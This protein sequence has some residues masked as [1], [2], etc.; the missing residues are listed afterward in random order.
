MLRADLINS[1]Q[2]YRITIRATDEA[3]PPVLMKFMEEKFGEGVDDR[4][5]VVNGDRWTYD[6]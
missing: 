4:A 6:G 1:R 3:V 2:H 5:G